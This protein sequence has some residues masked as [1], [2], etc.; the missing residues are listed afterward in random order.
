MVSIRSFNV[1]ET[2]KLKW[3]PIQEV[4]LQHVMKCGHFK[5]PQSNLCHKDCTFLIL[6]NFQP[7]VAFTLPYLPSTSSTFLL[8]NMLPLKKIILETASAQ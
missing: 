6:L 7:Q 5:A 3:G 8:P 4:F 1:I 2:K